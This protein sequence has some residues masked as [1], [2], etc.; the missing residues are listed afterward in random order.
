[1]IQALQAILQNTV[2]RL[3]SHATTY[4]PSILAAMVI[5]LASW[6]FAAAVRWASLRLFKAA[7]LDSFLSE[8]GLSSMMGRWGRTPGARILASGAYW[9]ILILG[10][11]TALDVF[12]TQMTTQ[13]IQGAVFLLPKLFTTGVI[14]LAGFWLARYLGRSILVWASNE[15]LPAPRRWASVVRVGVSFVAIVV[16]AQLLDFAPHV[17]LAAFIIVAGGAALTFS[18]AF[19]LGAR[20]SVRGLFRKEKSQAEENNTWTHI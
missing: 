1:M 2:D 20:D 5:L 13:I 19:G 4:L 3:Y 15:E 16:A 8:S 9:T 17:F 14:L 10:A 12:N 6:A 11:L 18:L 7:A